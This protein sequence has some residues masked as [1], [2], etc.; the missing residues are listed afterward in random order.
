MLGYAGGFVG[1]LAF[2]WTLD[3]AGGMSRE[4]WGLAFAGVAVV[5]LVGQLASE[6][7]RRRA[8]TQVL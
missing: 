3:L 7:L 1:P 4:A 6:A 8:G 2:G 5:V